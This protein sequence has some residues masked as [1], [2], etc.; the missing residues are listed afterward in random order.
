MSAALSP[1]AFGVS[2]PSMGNVTTTLS[3]IS[4]VLVIVI[5]IMFTAHS[6]SFP[7]VYKNVHRNAY[8]S[9]SVDAS[10][11]ITLDT[12]YDP[13]KILTGSTFGGA[14]ANVSDANGVVTVT[15]GNRHYDFT[16]STVTAKITSLANP[17]IISI[18]KTQFGLI[19]TPV[20]IDST[21]S[22]Y[23]GVDPYTFDLKVESQ[24]PATV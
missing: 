16:K 1:Q 13:Y 24:Q 20:H 14:S 15:L 17:G 12:V 21:F 11:N 10:G 7:R 19:L 23:S 9:V 3:V 4:A 8:A 22:N 2:I 5:L 6:V 18:A